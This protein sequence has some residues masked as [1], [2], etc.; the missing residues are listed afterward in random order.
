MLDQNLLAVLASH[1]TQDTFQKFSSA[2]SEERVGTNPSSEY[3]SEKVCDIQTKCYWMVAGI[4]K[5][6]YV[7]FYKLTYPLYFSMIVEISA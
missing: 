2:T 1:Y 6:V 3:S 5:M 7:I 4:L